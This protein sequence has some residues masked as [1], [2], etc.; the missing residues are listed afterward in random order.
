MIRRE[1]PQKR[2][3]NS[4]LYQTK[5]LSLH[6]NKTITVMEI[7]YQNKWCKI[8]Y[9]GTLIVLQSKSGKYN[10]QYFNSVDEAKKYIGVN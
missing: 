3:K 6:S 9:K 8:I 4:R 7:A 5:I 2:I 10:D 1:F